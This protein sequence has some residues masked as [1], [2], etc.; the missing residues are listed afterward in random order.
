MSRSIGEHRVGRTERLIRM[1]QGTTNPFCHD[2]NVLIC[3][4]STATAKNRRLDVTL[5]DELRLSKIIP[6]S[7]QSVPQMGQ[8]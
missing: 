5:P 8:E 6:Y 7:I 1:M 2:V 3:T 4:C